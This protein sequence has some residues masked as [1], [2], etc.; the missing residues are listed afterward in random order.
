MW[1][2]EMCIISGISAEQL[3]ALEPVTHTHCELRFLEHD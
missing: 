2:S 1:V 3:T